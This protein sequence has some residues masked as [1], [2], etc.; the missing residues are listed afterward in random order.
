MNRI[1]TTASFVL[2]LCAAAAPAAAQQQIVESFNGSTST[3][4]DGALF[5]Q[6]NDIV[7]HVLNQGS[8][9]AGN[10]SAVMSSPAVADGTMF[11]STQGMPNAPY[12][13]RVSYS[14]INFTYA[15]N[16]DNYYVLAGLYDQ[17][18]AIQASPLWRNHGLIEVALVVEATFSAVYIGYWN[19]ADVTHTWSGT[20]WHVGDANSTFA[21]TLT[22]NT[23]Y[24][25]RITRS[26]TGYVV[27][28]MSGTTLVTETT[29]IP[30]TGPRGAP[31][32]AYFATGDVLNDIGYGSAT[33]S[34]IELPGCYGAT[35]DAGVDGTADGGGP[36]G[37]STVDTTAD[38]LADTAPAADSTV[39]TTP[40]ADTTSDG[41]GG[42]DGTTVGDGSTV[43]DGGDV[44]IATDGGGGGDGVAGDA[45]RD[46]VDPGR[47]GGDGGV[48]DGG[49]GGDAAKDGAIPNDAPTSGSDAKASGDGVAGDGKDGE[50]S[51]C[52]CRINGAG[53]NAG[54]A[55]PLILLALA[56]LIRRRRRRR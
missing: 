55:W 32:G 23:P 34:E 56:L 39:D 31:N 28:V 7:A 6:C 52:D 38:V 27:R 19:A 20:S 22:P 18:P 17:T 10:S 25:V 9:T 51:G 35:G 46:S 42:G 8:I 53:A 21:F 1:A 37:D 36:T 16:T 41:G 12:V 13:A 2:A 14:T 4:A 48:G 33:L 47:D 24:E 5:G 50:G 43:V 29:P 3:L 15:N 44:G 40:A 26:A 54:T 30:L 49:G 45:P 11:A